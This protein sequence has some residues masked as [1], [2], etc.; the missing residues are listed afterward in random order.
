MLKIKQ[1]GKIINKSSFKKIIIDLPYGLGDQIMCFPI[2][3]SIKKYNSNINIT[4]LT[5]NLS[6]IILLK[7]N[8]NIDNIKAF[9]FKYTIGGMVKFFVSDFWEIR[10]FYKK[11]NFDLYIVIHQNILRT[12]L[13]KLLPYK[14]AIEN[15]EHTHKTKEVENILNYL[16]IPVIYNY[17]I[18]IESDNDYLK[19]Q[20]VENKKNILID[21]YAQHLNKDP[22]QWPFFLKLID[23]LKIEGYNVITV[24]INPTHESIAGIIDLVNKTSFDELL[25]LI[26]NAKLVIAMDTGIFH[27]SYSLNTPVI[28]L[29]GPIDPID[30]I[31]FDKKLIVKTIY[32][33][34]LCSPC[35]KNKVDIKCLK[36]N[37]PYACMKGITVNEVYNEIKKLYDFA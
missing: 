37:S 7:K 28:G 17:F 36:K 12:L 2:F 18:N 33:N 31:P 30:R 35:I 5:T 3:E 23:K 20:N 14:F 6:A 10:R 34:N 25:Q 16:Q 29:F 9:S 4:V 15:K 11:E 32:K 1:I 22:R 21:F 27:F 13:L 8:K 19:K 24:G 26:K